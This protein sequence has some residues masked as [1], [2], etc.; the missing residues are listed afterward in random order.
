MRFLDIDDLTS[1]ITCKYI[2]ERNVVLNKRQLRNR[3][4]FAPQ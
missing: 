1:C 2:N 3:L 4:S